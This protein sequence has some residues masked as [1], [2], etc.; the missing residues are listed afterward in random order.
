[1]QLLGEGAG[2]ADSNCK[3]QDAQHLRPDRVQFSPLTR[4]SSMKAFIRIVRCYVPFVILLMEIFRPQR[5]KDEQIKQIHE[6]ERSELLQLSA[7]LD[8]VCKSVRKNCGSLP[9]WG[10]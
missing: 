6:Y 8:Y 7:A 4:L 5:T 2:L 9:A 3:Q 1:V 10:P